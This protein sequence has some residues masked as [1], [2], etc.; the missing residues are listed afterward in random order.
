MPRPKT[1]EELL[2]LSRKNYSILVDFIDSLKDKELQ[3]EFPPGYLNRNIKDVL[4]HI[5]HWHLLVLDWYTIGMKGN[6]P[7][8]PAKGYTWRTLPDLNR[9]IWKKYENLDSKK[10]QKM[11]DASYTT[12]QEIINKHTTQELFEKKKYKWTGTTSLGAYLISATSS[13]YDW[14]YKLIKRCKRETKN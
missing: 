11:L 9:K 12:V 14:A 13:H 3:A 5:H 1:K 8:M 6:K 10:A 4:A 2:Q 7:H